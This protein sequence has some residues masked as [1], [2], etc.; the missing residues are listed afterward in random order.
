MVILAFL[1]KRGKIEEQADSYAC[2]KL[3]SQYE[4]CDFVR[5][6]NHDDYSIKKFANDYD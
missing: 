5:K 4:Y 6:A 3:I 2:N 1:L